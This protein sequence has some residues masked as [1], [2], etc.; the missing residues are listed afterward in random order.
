MKKNRIKAINDL[1]LNIRTNMNPYASRDFY[2]LIHPASI[3]SEAK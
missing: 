1:A 2:G 3:A